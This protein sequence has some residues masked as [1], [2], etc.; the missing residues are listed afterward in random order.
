MAR[1][2]EVL[3]A[4]L[5]NELDFKIA[6]DQHWYRIPVTAADKWLKKCWPPGWIAFYQTNAFKNDAH[7]IKYFARVIEIKKRTRNELFPDRPAD[8]NSKRNYYQLLIG[9]LKKRE[10]PIFS[11]RWR[12]IVFIPTTA[13]KF[14]HAV[15]INDLFDGSPIEDRLWAEM[16]IMKIQCERQELVTINNRNYFLDF[17]VYCQKGKL[18]IETDGDKWHHNPEQAR[19][20]N[21]RDN[22]LASDGWQRLRFSGHRVREALREYCVPKIIENI[23]NLGGVD[24]GN[25]FGRRVDLKLPGSSFQRDLFDC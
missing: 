20:D 17:A 8:K 5:N 2:G 22:D 12:R 3:V 9:H 15:E 10:H 24:E 25:Q 16:K 19:L 7:A 6:R 1:R 4:I 13:E 21:F 14:S 18:N 23:N 11:R